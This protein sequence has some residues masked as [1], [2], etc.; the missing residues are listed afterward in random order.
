MDGIGGSRPKRAWVVRPG[1]GPTERA[2]PAYLILAFVNNTLS[3]NVVINLYMILLCS[4]TR[5]LVSYIIIP[6]NHCSNEIC[7]VVVLLCSGR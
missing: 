7:E 6:V 5:Y 1:Q 2:F 3:I 4:C